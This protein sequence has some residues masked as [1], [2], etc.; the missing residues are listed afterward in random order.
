MA[1]ATVDEGPPACQMMNDTTQNAPDF[2]EPQVLSD[3]RLFLW[4]EDGVAAANYVALGRRLAAAGDL[5]R[6]P[7]HGSGLLLA[8]P[9]AMIPPRQIAQGKQLAPVI[10]DR[11]RVIVFKNGK[12]AGSMP[13]ASH[14]S[15]MLGAE[16]F[17]QQFR[18]LDRVVTVPMYVGFDVV[19][20]GFNDGGP[21][22]RV[23]YVGASAVVAE[24]NATINRFLD[25]MAFASNADRTNAVA[26]ALTVLLRNS[27]AGAKPMIAVTATKSHAG[28]DTIIA[29]AA[30][31]TPNISLSYEKQDW[32]LQKNF[33][34]IV[35]HHPD[36][37]LLNIENA[38]LNGKNELLASA[39]LERFLT[40]AAPVLFS[41]GTGNLDRRSNDL[42]LACSTNFGSLSEDLHNRSLPIHLAPVG[43]VA[44][45]KSPIGN[46]KLEFLPAHQDR[47][48]AELRGMIERWKAAGR[49]LDDT[50]KHPFSDWART[51]GGILQVAGFE[52]FLRNYGLQ[53]TTDDP[54]RFGLGVLGAAHPGEWLRPEDWGLV[55]EHLGLTRRLVPEADRDSREGRKRGLGTV[56]SAHQD[57]T[58]CTEMDDQVVVI[59]LK[60]ARRRF[61]GNKPHTRYRFDVLDCRALPEDEPTESDDG[62]GDLQG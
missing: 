19:R 31:R 38:R 55:V 29:F 62:L 18:P 24:G 47:I 2:P 1:Q 36:V 10:T 13:S 9:C 6:N 5:Y 21:G 15:T 56:L 48:E 39:F 58:F 54:V 40:D 43:D 32:A 23:Y 51:V 20:P 28:K 45:R 50:V 35:Q 14:M 34:A 7:Q 60:K 57:E 27:W 33:A 4:D 30:G 22:Q 44:S 46:P 12:P 49:P 16:V 52:D 25:V 41:T 42:V 59:Q 3:N 61:G 17:L 11:V 8:S 26:A 37:G 53:K